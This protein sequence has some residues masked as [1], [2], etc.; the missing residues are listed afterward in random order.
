M[1]QEEPGLMPLIGLSVAAF[2]RM[3]AAMGTPI[4]WDERM[5]MED[6][7]VVAGLVWISVSGVEA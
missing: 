7:A 2:E 1:S 5:T 6:K 4:E 3:A